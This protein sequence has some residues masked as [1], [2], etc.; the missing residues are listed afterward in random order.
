[1]E[2][3]S[4]QTNVPHFKTYVMLDI[5]EHKLVLEFK[6]IIIWSVSSDTLQRYH[7]QENIHEKREHILLQSDI[8]LR[9]IILMNM[10]LFIEYYDITKWSLAENGMPLIL[11]FTLSKWADHVIEHILWAYEAD[12]RK[13][14][15]TIEMGKTGLQEHAKQK[16]LLLL[17]SADM[18]KSC[19]ILLLKNFLFYIHTPSAVAKYFVLTENIFFWAYILLWWCC[20]LTFC[21]FY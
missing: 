1:M 18:S 3:V 20:K 7:L 8:L 14:L 9:C 21:G 17:C 12:Q 16:W 19:L 10:L 13:V 4:V 15:L 6:N 5:V 11:S 2:F